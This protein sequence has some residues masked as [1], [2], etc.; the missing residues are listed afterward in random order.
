MEKDSKKIEWLMDDK[1]RMA[2]KVDGRDLNRVPC[3]EKQRISSARI[4]R[5]LNKSQQ[6]QQD[7]WLMHKLSQ[8]IDDLNNEVESVEWKKTESSSMPTDPKAMESDLRMRIEHNETELL[9]FLHRM[10]IKAS[11]TDSF[12]FSPG[13][14]GDLPIQ[15]CFLLDLTDIGEMVINKYF[16]TPQLLSLPYTNDLDP[17]RDRPKCRSSRDIFIAPSHPTR[18]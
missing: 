2:V 8:S 18:R 16:N 1:N 6:T 9:H 17:W 15:D 14:V 5:R 4:C 3:S 13:P 12:V 10:A 11:N 7:G